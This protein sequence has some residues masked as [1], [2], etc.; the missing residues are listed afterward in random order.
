MVAHLNEIGVSSPSGNGRN[1]RPNGRDAPPVLPPR[2]DDPLP[3]P[4]VEDDD[5]EEGVEDSNNKR[6]DGTLVVSEAPKP[7]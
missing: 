4:P 7:L 2:R 6:N 3:P 1:S 5:D